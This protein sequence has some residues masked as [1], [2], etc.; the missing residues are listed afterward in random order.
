MQTIWKQKSQILLQMFINLKKLN[1]YSIYLSRGVNEFMNNK[2]IQLL[3]IYFLFKKY[4]YRTSLV[5][6]ILDTE[7]RHKL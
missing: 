3:K 4:R 2:K 1:S 7:E 6:S 5:L